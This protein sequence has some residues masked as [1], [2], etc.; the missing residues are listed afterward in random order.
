MTFKNKL[1]YLKTNQYITKQIKNI[2]KKN[3]CPCKNIW[4]NDPECST[5]KQKEATKKV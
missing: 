4:I 5:K 3:Q 2:V 1:A